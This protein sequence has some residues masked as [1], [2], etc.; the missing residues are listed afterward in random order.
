MTQVWKPAG[1]RAEH[2]RLVAAGC[3]TVT[4][5]APRT[6]CEPHCSCPV[7]EQLRELHDFGLFSP[8]L[9]AL[10]FQTTPPTKKIAQTFLIRGIKRVIWSPPRPYSVLNPELD[11]FPII[12]LQPLPMSFAPTLCKETLLLDPRGHLIPVSHSLWDVTTSMRL[13]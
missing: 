1:Q 8:K 13:M 2:V 10:L 6:D 7:G 3:E 12:E 5:D 9:D 11:K 4:S